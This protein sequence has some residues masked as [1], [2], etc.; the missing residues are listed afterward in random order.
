MAGVIQ[1]KS[2]IPNSVYAWE[3]NDIRKQ[4]LVKYYFND[5]NKVIKDT[6]YIDSTINHFEEVEKIYSNYIISDNYIFDLNKLKY[7]KAFWED[8]EKCLF[9]CEFQAIGDTIFYS[10]YNDSIVYYYIDLL[11]DTLIKIN[12]DSYKA[13]TLLSPNKLMGLFYNHTSKNI[14]LLTYNSKIEFGEFLCELEDSEIGFGNFPM[15][16]INNEYFLTQISNGEIV[17]VSIDGEIEDFVSIKINKK[18]TIKPVLYKDC[19]DNYYYY[20]AFKKKFSLFSQY[21][22]IEKNYFLNLNKEK[23]IDTYFVGCN[24]SYFFKKNKLIVF[25]NGI[26]IGSFKNY[27][28]FVFDNKIFAIDYYSDKFRMISIFEIDVSKAVNYPVESKYFK[29]IEFWL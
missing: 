29:L 13:Y 22:Y 7:K 20:I 21:P 25:K 2:Q 9:I 1:V 24:F 18:A 6:L 8:D 19:N 10:C 27:K 11:Y 3:T 17:K 12:K 26:K 5:I 16:W 28:N 15:V 14:E 23:Y 4:Y